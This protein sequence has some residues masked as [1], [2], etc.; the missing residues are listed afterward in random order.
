MRIGI[1]IEDISR[2]KDLNFASNKGFY[3]KIFTENEIKYCLGKSNPSKHFAVRYC[4]K[5]SFIKAVDEKI[6]YKDIEILIENNKPKIEVKGF[7]STLS[8]T[9]DK[10]KAVAVVIVDKIELLRPNFNYIIKG[11]FFILKPISIN[12]VNEEYVGWLNNPKINKYLEVRHKKQTIESIYGYINGLRRSKG[13]LFGIFTKENKFVGTIPLDIDLNNLFGIFGLMIGNFDAQ[14]IGAGT[15][16]VVL[17]LEFV[18]SH[19]KI[20][21]VWGGIINGHSK[22]ISNIEKL[23]FKKEGTYRKQYILSNGEIRDGIVYGILK[24]EWKNKFIKNVEIYA[25][26]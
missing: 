19:T 6:N 11:R 12:E 13:E 23:G 14:R 17:F 1:D 21:R 4:A 5:E 24:E 25:I 15:E 2:F 22:S 20:R 16:A 8:L 26:E 9:H 10:D 7:S 3:N 18:F